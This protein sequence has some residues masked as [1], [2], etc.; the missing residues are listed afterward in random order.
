MG[1]A[2]AA[3]MFGLLRHHQSAPWTTRA[4]P[5]PDRGIVDRMLRAFRLSSFACLPPP[6]V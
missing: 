1:T 3:I 5:R 6:S 2:R 4:L